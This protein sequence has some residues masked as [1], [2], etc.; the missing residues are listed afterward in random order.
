MAFND[1]DL[2]DED[3][4]KLGT[5][6]EISGLRGSGL[7]QVYFEDNDLCHIE[8][9]SGLRTLASVYGGLSNARGKTIRYKTDS[10]NV[11]TYFQ[12]V[13]DGDP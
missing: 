13:E 7:W 3:E 10:L 1:P 6:K 11:M 5:I 4:L 12:P 9:G 8:S 2:D